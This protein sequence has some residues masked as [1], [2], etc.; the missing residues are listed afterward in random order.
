MSSGYK[1]RID[2]NK[3]KIVANMN[4]G[5]LMRMMSVLAAFSA[6]LALC[7][8]AG[9]PSGMPVEVKKVVKAARR[10]CP[11]DFASLCSYPVERPYPLRD[12]PD[13]VSMVEYYNV[14]MD[15]SLRNVITR[16]A[17]SEWSDCGW[18]GWTL[19]DGR[20]L[21]IDDKIYSIPYIS[22]EER[23][24]L[25]SLRQ[26][27]RD[28]WPSHLR[29]GWNPVVCLSSEPEGAVFRIDASDE[30]S[31]PADSLYRLSVY[32]PD[33]SL[34]AEPFTV[35]IG[36]VGVEGS[37]G[38][39]MFYFRDKKGNSMEYTPDDTGEGESENMIW[40]PLEGSPRSYKVKK[41]YW[42][43]LLKSPGKPGEKAHPRDRK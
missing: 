1:N 12:L 43:D 9:S 34:L 20:Y 15:D 7:A 26:E 22:K 38:V 33:S 17:L 36:H 37:A 23:M 4:G 40:K 39:R 6:L 27:E 30:T 25:D 18:R 2:L 41:A 11:S 8:C 29:K 3:S 24:M 21:W 14:I 16:S 10:E 32:E 28:S 42:R 5:T 19:R 13:S 35:M 31:T